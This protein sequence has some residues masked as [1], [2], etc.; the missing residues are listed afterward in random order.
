M[1]PPHR[2]SPPSARPPP[3]RSSS[4]PSPPLRATVTPSPAYAASRLL[5]GRRRMGRRGVGRRWA[6]LPSLLLRRPPRAHCAAA[7]LVRALLA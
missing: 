4:P 3:R 7:A 5:H 2:L 1:R 6:V